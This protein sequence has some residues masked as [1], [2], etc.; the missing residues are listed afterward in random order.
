MRKS[1]LLE[2]PHHGEFAAIP[3][4]ELDYRAKRITAYLNLIH[5]LVNEKFKSIQDSEFKPGTEITRYFELLASNHPLRMAYE[6][7][8]NVSDTQEKIDKQNQLRQAMQIGSIDVNIM[9][10][11]D[12]DIYARRTGD[13]F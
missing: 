9:T 2:K 10:K 8:L 7:M 12:R 6:A 4:S 1:L 3:K 13:V 5:D 11:L